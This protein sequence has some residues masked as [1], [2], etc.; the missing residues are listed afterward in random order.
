[1]YIIKEGRE[2]QTLLYQALNVCGESHAWNA[3]HHCTSPYTCSVMLVYYNVFGNGRQR[4][5]V[6]HSLHTFNTEH[7][8]VRY[9]LFSFI[10]YSW[11]DLWPQTT[12]SYQQTFNLRAC[13]VANSSENS[14]KSIRLGVILFLVKMLLVR[15][16]VST[17][18]SWNVS[19]S[20]R[21][22]VRRE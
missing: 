20:R 15:S 8:H 5:S 22:R 9:S 11:F 16:H 13:E 12:V 19:C 18:S 6:P 14:I 1:M 4:I 3:N 17:G 10:M 21:Q 7:G 2:Y